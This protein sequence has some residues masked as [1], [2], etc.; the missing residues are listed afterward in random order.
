MGRKL[1]VKGVA[2]VE[3]R[4]YIV[5]GEEGHF[6]ME[7]GHCIAVGMVGVDLTGPQL[8]KGLQS[9]RKHCT[10]NWVLDQL[11]SRKR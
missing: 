11:V 8:N 9:R 10:A 2:V 5:V 6:E 3:R 4:L 1:V 7:R